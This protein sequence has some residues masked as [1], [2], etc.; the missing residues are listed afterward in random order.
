M[1]CIWTRCF[2]KVLRFFTSGRKGSIQKD[3]DNFGEFGSALDEWIIDI[4]DLNPEIYSQY[5]G[6]SNDIVIAN[7]TR[8]VDAYRMRG[9]NPQKHILFRVP[10]IPGYNSQE[11]VDKSIKALAEYGKIEAFRYKLI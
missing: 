5:T 8:L 7:Y 9:I 3:C 11:D 4:K 2:I 6:K 1:E 10:T